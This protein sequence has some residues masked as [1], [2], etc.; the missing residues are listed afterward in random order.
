[1]PMTYPYDTWAIGSVRAPP[2][3]LANAMQNGERLLWAATLPGSR[4]LRPLIWLGVMLLPGVLLALH[5]APWAQSMAEFCADDQSYSCRKLYRSALPMLVVALI[6]LALILTI[7]WK[8]KRS[9]STL[10]LGVSTCRALM[11]D[12]R[13]PHEVYSKPLDGNPARVD[14]FGTVWFGKSK[15]KPAFATL[16]RP[17]ADRAAYFA[18]EGRFR[19]DLVGKATP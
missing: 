6:S 17:D 2:A 3:P 7:V 13:K 15:T 12:G 10:Y 18:N 19:I 4:T 8:A 16:E 9:P 5:I 14:V 1:M 11:I